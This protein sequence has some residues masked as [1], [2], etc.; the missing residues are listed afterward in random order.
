MIRKVH[1]D[2]HTH[3]D[4]PEIGAAFDPEEF[5]GTLAD[6]HVNCLATPGKCHFGNIYFD[7]KV[8][9][10]HPH[11]VRPDLFPATV[12]ACTRRGI[13][14]QAYWT[15]GLDAAAAE[16]HPHW[17][18][19]FADGN[20]GRWGHYLHMC[21]ASA[22]IAE[23]VIPEVTEAIDRCPGLAGFWFDICLYVSGAFYSEGFE[24]LARER[25][26]AEA[27]DPGKRWGLARRIVRERCR[28]LD[29]VIKAKL[30]RA[31]NYFNSLVNPGEPENVPL[32]PLQEVENPVLFGGPENMTARVRWLRAQGSPVLGLVS[33]FQGPWADPGTLRTSDQMRFDVAR[34]VALGCG[35]SMGDHRHP[36]GSLEPEVYRRLAGIYADVE[37][38][39][40]WLDGATHCREAVLL[41]S[42]RRGAGSDLIAPGLPESTRHAARL[43]E[44]I[45]LQFD[46]V[47]VEEAIPEAELVIWPG[48]AP[49]SAELLEGLRAHAGRGGGLLVMD[50]ALE[51]LEDLC[52]A[53]GLRWRAEAA[54]PAEMGPGTAGCGHVQ[55]AAASSEACGPAGEFIR[56]RPAVG[57]PAFS[58]VSSQPTRLLEVMDGTEVLA[59][60]YGPV[61]QSPPFP[62][63]QP[64]GP[65]IVQKGRT[66]YSAAPL[67]R[68]DMESGTPVPREMIRVLCDRLLPTRLVR[69]DG[70]SS[71][72]AHLHR[73]PRG[74]ALHLVHW[75]MDRWARQPNPT[76][77][78]PRLGPV[79]ITLTVPQHVTRVEALPAGKAVSFTRE[80]GKCTFTVPEIHVWQVIGITT[81]GK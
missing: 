3:P 65:A 53:R 51:G 54:R 64:S 10:P 35:V 59:D 15:L 32:Q 1:L 17:R 14:V 31:E 41:S 26:G 79:R 11:L 81:S 46:I 21:F 78:F 73:A 67:F 72:A 61:S 23:M 7:T 6:A 68:E 80:D 12:E 50:A 47:S 69:H 74:Y 27:Q 40:P 25:L 76:A 22:Y 5:A 66:I 57:G 43:L 56:L 24:R 18:Q 36:D 55:T 34:T 16:S 60:R 29:A 58:Q 37:A 52:G 70:G 75:A 77:E 8:G 28:Q 45:G 44:E 38:L 39:Q 2:F 62:A 19:R 20:Y 42:I 9:R 48:E 30:P 63:R 13:K 71:V 49:A 4:T 33:R